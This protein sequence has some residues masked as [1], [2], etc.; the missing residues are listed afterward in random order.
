MISYLFR[1]GSL[2]ASLLMFL[3]VPLFMQGQNTEKLLNRADAYFQSNNTVDAQVLYKQVLS[4]DPSNYKAAYQLGRINVYLREYQEALRWYRKASEIDPNRNDTLYLQIGLAY[5]RL[6]NYRKAKD[7]FEEFKKRHG[8][9]DEYYERAELEIRGCELAEA[10]LASLPDYR[11][12]PVSFNS[13]SSDR[14]PTYLDQRQEDKFLVFASYRPLP[15][16]KAK[17]DRVT[18]EAKDADLYYVIRENDSIF[19][20]ITRFPKKRINTKTNDGPGSVSGDGQTMFFSICNSKKNRNG[21]SIFMS[22]YD[23]VKKEWGKATF[24]ESI[25]GKREIIVNSR[26]KTKM[27]PTDDREPFIAR[28]G[29]T[30]YFVSDREGG[31]G[32]FDIWFSRRVGTGWSP[33]QNIG[34]TINTPFNESS[35][36]PSESGERLF[37]AS[38][39]LAGFGGLDLYVAEG[40]IG[41]YAEPVNLGAPINTSYNDYGSMWMDED[42]LAYFTSDRP[43]GQ[44]GDDIYRARAIYRKP[45]PLEIAVKGMIRDKQTLQPIEFAT[46][47][48]YEKDAEGTIMVLDT[49]KTDQSARFEFPL[50]GDKDYKILGNAPE[51]FANEEE[52]STMGI[53]QNTEIVQNVDIELERM[54]LEN[55]YTINNIYYDFDEYYLRPD[56][57][58]ELDGLLDILYKNPNITIQLNSHTDSNGTEPYNI[59]LS[60]NRAKAVVKYLVD[61]GINPARLS[62]KGFGE[63]QLMIYPELSDDDEQ[64]NRRTEFRILT[65][66]FSGTP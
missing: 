44:G 8:V 56:A 16:K 6:N 64:A 35:P 42:S 14:Y 57:L 33:P 12:T 25:A 52:V 11:I 10:S 55:A 65:L 54:S 19:G 1:R 49:F 60:N 17:R 29:R 58:T 2:V 62:W 15:K 7:Y 22:R 18:G 59:G 36:F 38:E 66:N 39:G 53:D 37:F 63:S 9:Q 30:L 20:E 4:A 13:T 47:I 5:K 61:N 24:M 27:V 31:E 3:V 45:P 43:G 51:Y 23:P 50:E 28:D 41:S 40:K 46:A 34:S 26:G 32:G 21:C 48:L